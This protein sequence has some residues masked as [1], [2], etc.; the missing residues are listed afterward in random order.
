MTRALISVLV[1][2]TAACTD[3][4]QPVSLVDHAAWTVVAMDA[5]PFE[6]EPGPDLFLCDE[7]DCR[8]EELDG[9]DSFTVDTNVCNWATVEQPLRM[10][11][12]AGDV[13]RVRAFWFSQ[14]DF[15]PA[16]EAELAVQVGDEL[17][18]ERRVPI[19]TDGEL[20]DEAVVL[21]TAQ[22]LDAPVYF[23]IGNHGANTWN[24]LSVTRERRRTCA[25]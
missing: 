4:C 6:P 23:H 15:F 11:L 17:L 2:F 20:L 1:S 3:P 5:D 8:T 16:T 7:R 22:P 21:D 19:P 12:E 13:V 14:T 9:L 10:E 24:I 18:V 25:E